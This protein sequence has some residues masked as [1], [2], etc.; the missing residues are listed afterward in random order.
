M[1][2][3][4]PFSEFPRCS[5]GAGSEMAFGNILPIKGC[6]ERRVQARFPV[7]LNDLCARAGR[8]IFGHFGHSSSTR[9]VSSSPIELRRS[10]RVQADSSIASARFRHVAISDGA[11]A[12]GSSELSPEETSA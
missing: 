5:V 9:R 10:F 2:E 7:F 4:A 1:D 11:E 6:H 12:A 8:D 3:R